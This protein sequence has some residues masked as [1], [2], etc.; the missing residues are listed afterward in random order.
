MK[1]TYSMSYEF[2][3]K[4]P[5]TL[6]GVAEGSVLHACLRK[7]EKAAAR[8]AKGLVKGWCSCVVVLERIE[9]KE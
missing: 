7:A 2:M 4:P 6:R 8:Q 5:L 1:C 9:E 3:E